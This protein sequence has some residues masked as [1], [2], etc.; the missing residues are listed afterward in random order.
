M[1]G[2]WAGGQ[3]CHPAVEM[4]IEDV[5]NSTVILADHKLVLVFKNSKV[6]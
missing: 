5:N 1:E 6:S 4:A 2:G 3:A